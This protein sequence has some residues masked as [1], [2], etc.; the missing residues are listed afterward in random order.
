MALS[1]SLSQ[2]NLGV[3]GE[4]QRGLHKPT[5]WEN[6]IF[7]DESKYNIFG[8]DDKQKVWWKSSTAMHVKNGTNRGSG[9]AMEESE[10]DVGSFQQLLLYADEHYLAGKLPLGD[11]LGKV[12][13]GVEEYHQRNVRPLR[14]HAS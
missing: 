11:H 10:N 1:D 8:S 12:L 7:V 4:T 3:Q 14:F 2:I 13:H 5:D 6:V 9:L